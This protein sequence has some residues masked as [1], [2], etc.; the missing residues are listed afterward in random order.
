MGWKGCRLAVP[1]KVAKQTAMRDKISG[2]IFHFAEM[3]C[4]Q[5][6]KIQSE[7]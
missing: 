4:L 7:H 3:W 2:N 6:E 5:P 1:N